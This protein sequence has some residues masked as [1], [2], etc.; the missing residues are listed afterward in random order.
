MN[1]RWNIISMIKNIE[2]HQISNF[3]NCD[4]IFTIIDLYIMII[5][6]KNIQTHN[7]NFID[8]MW[9]EIRSWVLHSCFTS[10]LPNNVHL[11]WNL[12]N[13]IEYIATI[14][15]ILI[16]KIHF[17]MIEIH[18]STIMCSIPLWHSCSLKILFPLCNM[19]SPIFTKKNLKVAKVGYS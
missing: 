6:L 11:K 7:K 2:G 17:I 3:T 4:I 18:I 5:L 10:T 8:H 9:F 1:S 13:S 14:K 16:T 19:P 15:D 12:L